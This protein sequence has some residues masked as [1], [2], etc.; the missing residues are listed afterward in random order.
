M[1][2]NNVLTF[3]RIQKID[4][5]QNQKYLLMLA[6]SF[7]LILTGL[8][9]NSFSEI[10][11]GLS[12]IVTSPSN[13]ITDYV[14]VGNLGSAFVNSGI[15][16]FLSIFLM[17]L[18]HVH[19][20]GPMVAAIFTVAGYSFFGKNLYNSIPII[21][22]VQLYARYVRRPY[23][24][25]AMV[26][27][28]GSS[29]SPVVS[30]ITFGMELPL[31]QGFIISYGAGILIG[32][33]LPP[34]ASQMLHFHHGFSLYNVGFSSGLIAMILTGILRMF[35]YTIKER[36]IIAYAHGKLLLFLLILFLLFLL[37]GWVL[38]RNAFEALQ[39]I[40]KTSGKLITD[41]V[42]IA[43]VGA[44]MINMALMGLMLTGYC[45][46]IQVE[47][48]GPIVGA[49][50]SAVGFSAFGN[51]LKNSFPVLLGVYLASLIAPFH[52]VQQTG[53]VMAAI[54]GTSLAPISGYYGSVYGILVG[55]LHMSLVN[56]V[57]Y[58]HGGLNLYNNGF[59][60]GFVAGFIVP[61]LD[62]FT[63]IGEKNDRT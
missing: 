36:S 16:T 38:E 25:F 30:Y 43:G 14:A 23:S 55:I 13:L 9:Q 34:V 4:P 32:F 50:L 12:R 60:S 15:L 21:L 53:A 56:N 17:R 3:Q 22:G 52:D 6:F 45:L 46:L 48:N 24:Q 57:S 7:L 37:V 19:M 10:F 31:W 20:T 2:D 51:H 59:S 27:L 28:F 11:Q 33:I 49:I 44:T 41:F 35:N 26:S 58:L 62:T 54:F 8:T 5:L 63:K 42:M 18:Y 40:F 39:K 47:L 1:K 61:L 29:L